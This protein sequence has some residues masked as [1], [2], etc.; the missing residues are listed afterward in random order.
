MSDDAV[1]PGNQ[2]QE[3]GWPERDDPET[4]GSN[5]WNGRDV[6]YHEASESNHGTDTDAPSWGRLRQIS[7]VDRKCLVAIPIDVK[8]GSE[9]PV[10][11]FQNDHN[12]DQS[13]E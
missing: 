7:R 6:Q 10:G 13:R 3:P 8:N 9:E 1:D 5:D 2:E 4:D 11:T 12:A